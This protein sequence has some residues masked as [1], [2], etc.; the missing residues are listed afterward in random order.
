M[1]ASF[2]NTEEN[3]V[4]AGASKVSLN[5]TM[6]HSCPDNNCNGE[7]LKG[8]HV[9]CSKCG[10]KVFLDCIRRRPGAVTLLRNYGVITSNCDTNVENIAEVQNAFNSVFDHNSPFAIYCDFCRLSTEPTM[11]EFVNRMEAAT[12]VK[13]IKIDK[14]ESELNVLK[15]K[16]RK[17][18]QTANTNGTSD[19]ASNEENAN[20]NRANVANN[21]KNGIEIAPIDG[22]YT[23]HA[24]RLPK[25]TTTE[26]VVAQ[27]VGTLEVKDDS[28]LVE[29][30]PIKRFRGKLLK[31]S[32]FKIATFSKI[33]CDRIVYMDGWDSNC[34]LKQFNF[35]S[36]VEPNDKTKKKKKQYTDTQIQYKQNPVD[37]NIAIKKKQISK[38]Q[39]NMQRQF[40]SNQNYHNNNNK[41]G[42]E[43]HQN[44]RNDRKRFANVN[45]RHRRVFQPQFQEK[46]TPF[47]DFRYQRQQPLHQPPKNQQ[48]VPNVNYLQ[49][50]FL[51]QMPYFHPPPLQQSYF[52]PEIAPFWH[53]NFQ[54]PFQSPQQYNMQYRN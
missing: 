42:H 44:I 15:S 27:I 16:Q 34:I 38:P 17:V 33:L 25:E 46:R 53:R 43:V 37:T 3:A 19:I 24:S 20:S 40:S 4:T 1:F 52:N 29:K 36:P 30:L 8:L 28:F 39:Q 2:F 18:L 5:D 48:F 21:E 32:S 22:V 41:H 9:K 35:A 31:F 26:A 50:P 12:K 51:Y 49:Q 7:S 23:I 14:L 11:R 10:S 45:S 6:T 47:N 13:Q 54:V